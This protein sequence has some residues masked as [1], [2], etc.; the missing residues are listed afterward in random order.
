MLSQDGDLSNKKRSSAETRHI[1]AI[2]ESDRGVEITL[3]LADPRNN[4]A[5]LSEQKCLG[6]GCGGLQL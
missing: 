2:V 6:S 1:L 4:G 3:L 5:T